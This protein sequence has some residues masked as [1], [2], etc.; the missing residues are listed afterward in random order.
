[1]ILS[2]FFLNTLNP[3]FY[4]QMDFDCYFILRFNCNCTG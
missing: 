3:H 1:M 2:D 4:E